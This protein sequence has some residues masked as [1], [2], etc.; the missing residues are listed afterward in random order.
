[1]VLALTCRRNR[2]RAARKSSVRVLMAF[3]SS[4]IKRIVVCVGI[5]FFT[6]LFYYVICFC[7]YLRR[8]YA[9]CQ[10]LVS[11]FRGFVASLLYSLYILV[12]YTGMCNLI[13]AMAMPYIFR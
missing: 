11:F 1:M 7:L 3:F 5:G 2:R 9:S 6:A 13:K 8:F 10:R 12:A 4:C